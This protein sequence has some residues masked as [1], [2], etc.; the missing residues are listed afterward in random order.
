[1]G[2]DL[3]LL[4][5]HERHHVISIHASR[6]GCDVPRI[7]VSGMD[8]EFQSTHPVW[9]ATGVPSSPLSESCISIHASRMGCDHVFPK[10][11]SQHVIFQ[12]THPVWDATTARDVIRSGREI[13]IHA[14]R[15]GCDT[16]CNAC[17]AHTLYFNPRIPYGMRL[18][19]VFHF[20]SSLGYFNPRIPYGMRPQAIRPQAVLSPFQ[21]THPVWDATYNTTCTV[22][23]HWVFQSTH[24]VWDATI[25]YVVWRGSK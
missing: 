23:D 6:M 4:R 2:C 15:M 1:M 25:L 14:S 16:A 10:Y 21:S 17:T 20:V 8:V 24:P 19:H 12:S 11:M 5:L 3:V 22:S 13:S 9:D 18:W 7:A